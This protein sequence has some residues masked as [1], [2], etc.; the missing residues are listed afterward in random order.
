MA[1]V[2][3]E[4]IEEIDCARCSVHATLAHLDIEMK[5]LLCT[6]SEKMKGAT[7]LAEMHATKKKLLHALR[8]N[9]EEFLV[10]IY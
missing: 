4:V 6:N 9:S 10:D 2:Q 8:T 3:L 7:A 1:Y 5:R